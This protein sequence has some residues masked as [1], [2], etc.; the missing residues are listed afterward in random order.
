M[1]KKLLDIRKSSPLLM[2][3]E[4]LLLMN[5]WDRGFE[6]YMRSKENQ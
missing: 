5:K 2:V 1:F 3:S 6:D 4:F